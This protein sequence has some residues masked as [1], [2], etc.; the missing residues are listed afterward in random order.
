MGLLNKIIKLLFG[1]FFTLLALPTFA[2][3]INNVQSGTLTLTDTWQVVP[4]T[5]VMDDKSLLVFNLMADKGAAGPQDTHLRGQLNCTTGQC[6]AIDFERYGSNGN[7][8]V[9]WQVIEFKSTSKINVQRGIE[10][11][12]SM[13]ESIPAQK[14]LATGVDRDKS[15]VLLSEFVHG[16]VASDDDF[17]RGHLNNVG[18]LVLTVGAKKHS[19]SKAEIAWQV[20]EYQDADVQSGGINFRNTEVSKT[21]VI[22]RV[23]VN[24]SWLVYNYY[25]MGNTQADTAF[26]NY[27]RIVNPQEGSPICQNLVSGAMRSPTAL[28]FKRGCASE[29]G[30]L[31]LSWFVIEFSDAT[32]TQ[33]DTLMLESQ[34]TEQTAVLSNA[35]DTHCA[36]T[37]A[38]YHQRGGK[39]SS[40]ADHTASAWFNA[41]LDT[42]GKNL[43]LS[44]GQTNN[45]MAEV[46]WFVVEF[47]GCGSAAPA[48]DYGDAPLSGVAPDGS[49]RNNYGAASHLLVKGRYLGFADPDADLANQAGLDAQG[50]DAIAND[51]TIIFRT[52]VP[53]KATT[54]P[55]YM[56]F[57]W[58][59]EKNLDSK[60]AA[61][62]GEVED[63]AITI[64]SGDQLIRNGEL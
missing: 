13:S 43:T 56:R 12:F 20:V 5:P 44:R 61:S 4:I 45:A 25:S 11:Q 59:T 21:A 64:Q 17:T 32:R 30:E 6:N 36:M 10:T 51:G 9:R 60:T 47:E 42:T 57:R 1:F 19:V 14:T 53:C 24:K 18:N 58:S 55:T 31:H 48:K 3:E 34:Q 26:Y 50:D 62:D 35:I 29:Q 16:G 7:V 8:T 15:F 63:Y 28:Q 22:N 54:K 49:S 38:G 52:A 23:D 39:S 46:G 33:H 37:T 2:A 40:S 27:D 41:V